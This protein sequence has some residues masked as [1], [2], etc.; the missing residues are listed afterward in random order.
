MC[1]LLN[2][3]VAN[4]YRLAVVR[5]SRQLLTKHAITEK[6]EF[7]NRRDSKPKGR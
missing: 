1:I 3:A 6:E 5:A 2:L 7:E 4:D